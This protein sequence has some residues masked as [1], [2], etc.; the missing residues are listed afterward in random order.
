MVL[1]IA[2]AK[3]IPIMCQ[4]RKQQLID[5]GMAPS[6]AIDEALYRYFEEKIADHSLVEWLIEEDG[7]VIATGAIAFMPFPPSYAN[8]SGVKGY[9]TNMYTA[10]DHRGKGIATM[11]LNKLL[12]EARARGISRV[13]L[14]ASRLG[15]PVYQ[16]FGFSKADDY[17]EMS[18]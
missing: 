18:L 6:N 7:R 3:D 10:P 5:E 17:M 2:T 13:W 16:R 15:K 1:R 4:I 14:H 8:P 12:D 9:I 11:L